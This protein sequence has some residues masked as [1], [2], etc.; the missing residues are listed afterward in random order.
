MQRPIELRHGTSTAILVSSLLFMLL[1]LTKGWALIGMV[2]IVFGAGV[3]LGSLARLPMGMLTDR[4]GGRGVFSALMLVS[5][6]AAWL[7]PFTTG[8]ASLVASAFLLGLAGSSFAI[9][10]AFVSRWTPGPQ[11][12][13]ALGVYGLGTL[14][15][16]AAVFGGPLVAAWLGWP[17]VFYLMGL[18][19]VAGSGVQPVVVASP[20]VLTFQRDL[21]GNGVVD[22]TRERVTF[23]LRP[24]DSVL[25]RDAGAGAQ[26]VI[27]DVRRLAFAYFDRGGAVAVD[28]SAIALVRITLEVG[29]GG[30]RVIMETAVSLRNARAGL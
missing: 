12:G 7:V 1:H 10:A 16:S 14:G 8:Y 27:E 3:L 28:P 17:S 22:P 19:L 6:V 20:T 5:A 9:G 13:T 2:P 26:P 29:H 25:R 23:V 18:L 30:S 4:Y 21:N 15:Q 11:Q 24:G